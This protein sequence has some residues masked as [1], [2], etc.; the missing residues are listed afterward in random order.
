L[1]I[2]GEK[3]YEEWDCPK[4]Q[5][6]EDYKPG[7]NHPRPGSDVVYEFTPKWGLEKRY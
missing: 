7:E 4:V 1:Q 2:P 5:I 3:I 6:L